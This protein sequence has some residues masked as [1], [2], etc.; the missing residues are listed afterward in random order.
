M[1]HWGGTAMTFSIKAQT[2]VKKEIAGMPLIQSAAAS[3]H[4]KKES[5]AILK[6]S[7]S[8]FCHSP[9]F[10]MKDTHACSPY[11]SIINREEEGYQ[12]LAG[13]DK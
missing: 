8:I 4:L 3:F 11:T 10:L 5:T 13:P 12:I 1:I 7:P 9:L 6:S 2:T